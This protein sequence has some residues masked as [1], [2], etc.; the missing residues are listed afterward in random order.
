MF[1]GNIDSI[2]YFL[3]EIAVTATI[4]LL[5]VLHVTGR[6]RFSSSAAYLSLVGVGAALLFAGMN[7]PDSVQASK[8]LFEGMLAFDGF[9]AFFKV[10]TALTT[11]VVIV[12]SMDSAELADRSRAEYFIFLLSILLGM[13]LL[14][15][16]ADIVMLYIAIELV[17]IPSYLLAGY[18]KGKGRSTEAAMKYVVYGATASGTMIYGFSLLFGMTGTT[19]L[20]AIGRALAAGNAPV[21]MYLAAILVTV[22]FGYKI[23]AVPFHMWSPDVYE[24]APTPVTAFLSVGPKAVGLGVLIRFFYTVFASDDGAFGWRLTSSVDWPMLFAVLSAVTMTVG[25]LVAIGQKNVKRLLAYSSIAHAGY[26][27]M[28]FVLLSAIG[29]HA[30]L[31]YLV[32]Y[33]FMNL[34]AFYIVVLVSNRAKGEDI[35]DFSGLGSRAPFIACSLAVF[36]FSLTGIPPFSGFIGKVYL[37][38]E[39][40]NRQWYWLAV[41]AGLNGAV[42]LYYY[43]RIV[44]A[45]FLEEPKDA[46]AMPVAAFPRVMVGLMVFPTILLGVYWE[47]VSRM[48]T[49]AARMLSAF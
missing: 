22:G 10:L 18:L 21:A 6:N 11:L 26:M 12:M 40:I 31:F 2:R 4:L 42:S 15:S 33:L 29:L 3:P 37:F 48:T 47:P 1:L 35:S 46:S 27:L 9:G 14:P 32:V 36:L 24:G 8:T 44:K 17:S 7:S 45:M 16:A 49:A 30:I 34:G 23:A 5:V 13:F 43:A 38:A 28:G 25:N 39:V 20:S 19:Q 41:I